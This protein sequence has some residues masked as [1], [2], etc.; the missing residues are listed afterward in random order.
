MKPTAARD[1]IRDRTAYY[2]GRACAHVI[3]ALTYLGSVVSIVIAAISEL[4]PGVDRE[5]V[6]TIAASVA[7]VQSLAV[8]LVWFVAMAIFD[9]ADCALANLTLEAAV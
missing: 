8:T 2:G 5:L 7:L 4:P 6:V 3:M 9:K 1:I